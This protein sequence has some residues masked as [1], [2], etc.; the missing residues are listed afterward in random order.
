MS[1]EICGKCLKEFNSHQEYLDHTC[2]VTGYTPKDPEHQGKNF[3]LVQK[4]ALKRTGS[5]DEKKEKEIDDKF[6][7][8][9][10]DKKGE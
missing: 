1:K 2:E 5:L 10:K 9:K 4:N 3:G 8:R 6:K 7:K